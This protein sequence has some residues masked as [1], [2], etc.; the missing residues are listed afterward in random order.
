MFRCRMFRVIAAQTTK[1]RRTVGSY[2]DAGHAVVANP[3]WRTTSELFEHVGAFSAD[4]QWKPN[5]KGYN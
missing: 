2:V 4:P 3:L 5:T 1:T